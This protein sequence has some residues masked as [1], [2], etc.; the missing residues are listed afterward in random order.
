MGDE[1]I[2][3]HKHLWTDLTKFKGEEKDVRTPPQL[4]T[5]ASRR[6]RHSLTA[7]ASR[8]RRLTPSRPQKSRW[9]HI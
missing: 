9:K 5:L 3:E 4:S 2:A 7:G 1:E 6:R 8:V